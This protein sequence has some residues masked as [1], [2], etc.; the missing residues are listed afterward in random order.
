METSNL[1]KDLR[2]FKN[3]MRQPTTDSHAV[4][5]YLFIIN[6]SC[7]AGNMGVFTRRWQLL[8]N[9]MFLSA[10]SVETDRQS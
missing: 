6:A 10:K 3:P 4:K 9:L 1:G 2:F 8:S 7:T 5:F